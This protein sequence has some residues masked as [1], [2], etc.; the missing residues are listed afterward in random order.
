MRVVVVWSAESVM[1]V[2]D[3]F[4]NVTV[5][6]AVGSTTVRVVSNP[7]EV[8]PSKVIVPSSWTFNVVVFVVVALNAP[9]ARVPDS[10]PLT[11]VTRL[12]NCVLSCSRV[13]DVVIDDAVIAIFIYPVKFVTYL[14]FRASRILSYLFLLLD[15]L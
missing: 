2:P 6:S 8:A 4:G 3:A 10:R 12:L 14:L 1:T 15:F 13:F 5:R 11:S 7:S 9:Y